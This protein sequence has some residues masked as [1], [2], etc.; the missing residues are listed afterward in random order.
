M[1]RPIRGAQRGGLPAETTEEDRFSDAMLRKH[2]N[3]FRSEIV[4]N[5]TKGGKQSAKR[6]MCFSDT[7]NDKD[8]ARTCLCSFKSCLV[9]ST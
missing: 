2:L 8:S 5:E 9:S 7:F 3:Y 4:S 1:C 6:K